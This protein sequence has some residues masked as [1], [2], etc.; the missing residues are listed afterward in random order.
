MPVLWQLTAEPCQG[1]WWKAPSSGIEKVLLPGASETR[2]GYFEQ[3]DGGTIFLDEI[4]G[5]PR[6]NCRLSCSG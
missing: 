3:A 6:W 5:I 2:K 4:G 1:T